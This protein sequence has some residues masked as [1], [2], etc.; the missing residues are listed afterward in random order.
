MAALQSTT[1]PVRRILGDLAARV[2]TVTGVDADTL[3]VGP[4]QADIQMVVVTPT[5]TVYVG[6]SYVGSVITFH[7][8]GAFTA[9]VMVFSR[10]G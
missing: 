4:Q 10:V 5:T 7:A 2:Y 1:V 9:Q 6:A 3:N 8:S